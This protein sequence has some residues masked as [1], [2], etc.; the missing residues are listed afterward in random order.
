M[1]SCYH[2]INRIDRGQPL[3]FPRPVKRDAREKE[4]M[5]MH[6]RATG[7]WRSRKQKTNV[8]FTR[9]FLL[10]LK[11][12]NDDCLQ[13][14]QSVGEQII[15]FQRSSVISFKQQ[16]EKKVSVIQAQVTYIIRNTWSYLEGQNQIVSSC[17]IDI[18]YK[19]AIVDPRG[20]FFHE[21]ISLKK[22]S[23]NFILEA[24]EAFYVFNSP[25]V[26]VISLFRFQTF[27]GVC[28]PS[29]YPLP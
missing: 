22:V 7:V 17:V 26:S 18:S 19:N 29:G 23:R 1:G 12:K 2:V 8:S 10:G 11:K 5:T 20:D 9:A 15:I 27:S 3:L 14:V 25:T 6:A 24:A 16:T 21:E 28:R 4:Q 13:C